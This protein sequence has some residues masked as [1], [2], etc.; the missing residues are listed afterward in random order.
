MSVMKTRPV[1]KC[2]HCGRPLVVSFL[3]TQRPDPEGTLLFELMRNLRKIA[4]CAPCRAAYNY[5][6]SIG[7]VADWLRGDV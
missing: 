7:R 3:A 6:S 2:R 4:Y 5:Y 1:F